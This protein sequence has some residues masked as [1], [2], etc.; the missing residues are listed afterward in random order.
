MLL[1]QLM[2]TVLTTMIII[3]TSG[4]FHFQL[5]R[6]MCEGGLT[7]LDVFFGNLFLV[8]SSYS[9]LEQARMSA[10]CTLQWVTSARQ[11]L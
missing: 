2:S 4:T 1:C 8:L 3:W 9:A 7:L 10:G 11:L 6:G 5:W